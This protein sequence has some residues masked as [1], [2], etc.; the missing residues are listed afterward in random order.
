MPDDQRLQACLALLEDLGGGREQ[1][2]PPRP[3]QAHALAA[4]VWGDTGER[5]QA[6]QALCH[7]YLALTMLWRTLGLGLRGNPHHLRP[8]DRDGARLA[9][10]LLVFLRLHLR[11][12]EKLKGVVDWPAAGLPANALEGDGGWCDLCGQCC[13]HCGTVPAPPPGVSYPPGWYHALSGEALHFQ[14]FC[15]FLFQAL[16]QPLY[17]CGLH[18]IKPLPCRDFGRAD[19]ER[20]RPTRGL[21]RA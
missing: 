7:P 11:L 9:R 6:V 19:C 3:E 17:F 12:S 16:G 18:P 1:G 14:P 2:P 13:C 20:G 15:P 8:R 10:D 4:G 5:T 21:I